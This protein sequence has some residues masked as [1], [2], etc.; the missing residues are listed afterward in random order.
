M[1][2][3]VTVGLDGLSA[4]PAVTWG[5][6]E[7]I[8]RG[9]PLKLLHV[10]EWLPETFASA[11]GSASP[12]GPGTRRYWAERVPGAAAA[13]L[14]RRH[15]GLEIVAEQVAG[16][17]AAVLASAA[18]EAELLV[19]GFRA[20]GTVAA[21]LAGSVALDTVAQAACPV[22]L[23]PAGDLAR[24]GCPPFAAGIGPDGVPHREVVVGV[25]LA[26]PSGELIAFAFDAAARRAA[27]L[28][29]IHGRSLPGRET[30]A[31]TE[32]WRPWQERFPEV[33]VADECV[34]GPGRR[35]ADA[36]RSACLVVVARRTPRFP[37]G[38]HA[39]PVIR[40]VLHRSRAPVAVV[41]H[42]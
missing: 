11:G 20:R 22:V 2:R 3:T 17:P 7:A 25:D 30:R 6:R 15:P 27:A 38:P 32:V 21:F 8:R 36:A 40:A 28:R 37:A 18:R 13:G 39:G 24:D 16:R 42:D 34:S 10:W 26:R 29:V 23:V 19:L 12:R 5:A 4:G 35:L 9:L 14:R 33:E 41:P 31:P 1:S